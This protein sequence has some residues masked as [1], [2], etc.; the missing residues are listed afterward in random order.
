MIPALAWGAGGRLGSVWYP[1]A[2][3]R[4]NQRVDEVR[5]SGAL[6]VLPWGAFRRF[7]WNSGRT[8][9]D[10]APR[11]F[12]AVVFSDDRLPVGSTV[13]A[14]ETNVGVAL[15]NAANDLARVP[16]A[17]SFGATVVVSETPS[18]TQ[19]GETGSQLDVTGHHRDRSAAA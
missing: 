1:D 2:W 10:P 17:A 11:W 4:A 9:L 6:L 3:N 13:V 19:V 5:G 14:P 16:V 12:G 18:R 8:V 15:T 7:D